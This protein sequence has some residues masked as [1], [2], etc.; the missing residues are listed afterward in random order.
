MLPKTRFPRIHS[1]PSFPIKGE[2]PRSELGKIELPMRRPHHVADAAHGS[3]LD[4]G[5]FE[6]FA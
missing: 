1:L 2:V 3:D 4:I 5:C 6:L